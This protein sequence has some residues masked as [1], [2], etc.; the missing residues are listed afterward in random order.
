VTATDPQ[1]RTGEF[2]PFQVQ[3]SQLTIV[4]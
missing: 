1:G 3:N 4:E 2:R